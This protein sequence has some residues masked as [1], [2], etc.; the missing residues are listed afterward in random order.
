MTGGGSLRA[1]VGVAVLGRWR[2]IFIHRALAWLIGS[3]LLCLA[4]RQPMRECVVVTMGVRKGVRQAVLHS[5]VWHGVHHTLVT[6]QVLTLCL[7]L[8]LCL[9]LPLLRLLEEA[10]PVAC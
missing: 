4:L 2:W 1:G 10:L 7:I 9:H 5:H 6:V 3:Y 8:P